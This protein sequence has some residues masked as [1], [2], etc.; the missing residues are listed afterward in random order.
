MNTY[1][2]VNFFGVFRGTIN[3]R[4]LPRLRSN[5]VQALLAYLLLEGQQPVLRSHLVKLL[6]HGYT[7][8]AGRAS[9]RVALSNLRQTNELD[10]LLEVDTRSIVLAT[11]NINFWCDAIE[12]EQLSSFNYDQRWATGRSLLLQG[13]TAKADFLTGMEEIDSQPFCDW[14]KQKRIYYHQLRSKLIQEQWRFNT[15]MSQ[16]KSFWDYKADQSHSFLPTHY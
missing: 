1:L 2:R 12:L 15:E 16:S 9:L 11:N 13:S 6:W 14:L 8:E 3:D 4:P 5:K 7:E 10:I